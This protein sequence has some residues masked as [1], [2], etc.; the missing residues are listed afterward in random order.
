MKK[1]KIEKKM[2]KKTDKMLV[3]TILNTKKREGW[4]KVSNMISTSSRK[5]IS[6][7]LNQID[8]QSKDGETIVVPGKVLGEG[9][10]NKKVKI[11]A[12]KFSESAKAKL[13]KNKIEILNIDEEVK[14]N[15]EA[16]KVKIVGEI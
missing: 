8:K 12:L 15:P 2:K 16:K 13:K 5:R 11:V 6:L 3:G 14:N 10:L 1:S 9:E 7:N 4:L